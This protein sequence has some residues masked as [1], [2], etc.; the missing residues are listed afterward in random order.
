MSVVIEATDGAG[1]LPKDAEAD[2]GVDT[3]CTA[4]TDAQG[5]QIIS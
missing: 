1:L 5:G 3:L 4:H 2:R